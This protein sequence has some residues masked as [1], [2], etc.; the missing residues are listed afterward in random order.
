[1]LFQLTSTSAGFSFSFILAEFSP[2]FL[3]VLLLPRRFLIPKS[4]GIIVAV[5]S[6][7]YASCTGGY[8]TM[9]MVLSY[10]IIG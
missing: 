10:V 1:M 5:V 4:N 9:A 3:V 8:V 7:L 2:E 6:C